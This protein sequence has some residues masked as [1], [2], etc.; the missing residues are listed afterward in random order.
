M[1]KKL[2]LLFRISPRTTRERYLLSD[3]TQDSRTLLP[4]A[5]G[6]DNNLG[7]S[8]ETAGQTHDDLPAH[9]STTTE[10][11]TSGAHSGP[12]ATPAPRR[13]SRRATHWRLRPRI[14]GELVTAGHSLTDPTEIPPADGVPVD[15]V[16]WDAANDSAGFL[17]SVANAARCAS[18]AR[19]PAGE[20]A[21]WRRVL[22]LP[23]D[24][25]DAADE[26]NHYSEQL[27]ADIR[28]QRRDLTPAIHALNA[29]QRS[30]TS[31][32]LPIRH[33]ARRGVWAGP[34]HWQLIAAAAVD[35]ARDR[36]SVD[37][38]RA[39]VRALL[40]ALSTSF[41]AAGHGCTAATETLA[42]RAIER[43]GATCALSTACRR[44]RTITRI[45]AE[46]DL[47]IVHARGRWLRSIER[48]AARLHHGGRQ[49]RAANVV[50]ANVPKHLRPRASSSPTAP[51]YA[52]GLAARLT[53]RDANARTGFRPGM[54][55]ADWIM[56]K[57][58]AHQGENA[59]SSTDEQPSTYT[60]G[61][62]LQSPSGGFRVTHA[63]ASAPED[64]QKSSLMKRKTETRSRI[65]LRAWRIADDLSRDG[66]DHGLDA[67][68]Y[69]HLVGERPGQMTPQRFARLID[70][71][72]PHT[73]GTCE[74]MAALVHAA[75]STATGY[76][77]L[78]LHT[79][80]TRADAWW[81]TAL[82]RINWDQASAF[83]AWSRTAEVFGVDWRGA[84][85][86][87]NPIG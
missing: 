58:R 50:D 82:S 40:A 72:T 48:L 51:A 5:S 36:V 35:A 4:S 79:R 27:A 23:A 19:T 57:I 81:R 33:G 56:S 6:H 73:V 11:P 67:G 15:S 74:V 38:S 10:N 70:E 63:R 1:K 26:L 69:R 61:S 14:A 13:I 71:L 43:F 22:D 24:P 53:T 31:W 3:V 37:I 30:P 2:A 45:L 8:I 34:E 49:H 7:F 66:V 18:S 25:R 21:G 64:T 46:A 12:R 52:H 16:D 68:P 60:C 44:L 17:A 78:G 75:T 32:A 39:N 20:I 87:W 76:V 28:A 59:P 83:P 29:D 9:T 80:P 86:G 65:S 55:V 84:R 77:A 85:R 41:D 47:L 54:T 42:T 62:S